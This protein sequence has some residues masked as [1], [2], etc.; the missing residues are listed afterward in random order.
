MILFALFLAAGLVY[1][2]GQSEEEGGDGRVVLNVL[3]YGDLS[4][5][6]GQAW[7]KIRDKFAEEH[8]NIVIEDESL[9]DE[10]YH[11][12]AQALIAAK[13]VPDLMYLWP[14]PRSSYAYDAGIAT[15]QR[16]FINEE[17]YLASTMQPQGPD[18]EIWEVPLGLGITS[19]LYANETLLD[20]LGLEVPE[21]YEELV[22]MVSAIED[23]DLVPVAMGNAATWVMN[24]C[25][26]GTAVGRYGGPGWIEDAVAGEN[27]FTDEVFVKAL[28]SIK[29]MYDDGVLPKDSVQTDYGTALSLFLNGEA[30]FLLDG[31]W[32]S[33]GFEDMDFA[34][35][36]SWNVFPA[37]PGEEHPEAV[38]GVVNPG[39]GITTA[40]LEDEDTREAAAKL[41]RFINGEYGSKVRAEMASFIPSYKMDV[42]QLDV[43]VNFRKKADFYDRVD[44]LVDVP[45]AFI[46]E[47]PNTVLNTAMQEIAL[48]TKTP[49]QVAAEVEE[50]MAEER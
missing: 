29:M 44:N 35:D 50:A 19:V 41:L 40:A 24:S 34:Q 2:G 21:T 46:P 42:S 18:G 49:E 7:V 12:K 3:N 37:L 28:E 32:R 9:Y 27:S 45:D 15:D 48:G 30:V 14:G 6:E 10:A 23:A 39:Y 1:A 5:G 25:Y 26:L 33:A 22:G 47:G 31:H 13:E 20:E 36:V 38:S 11:Q 16:P 17:N 8:P 4:T 43:D